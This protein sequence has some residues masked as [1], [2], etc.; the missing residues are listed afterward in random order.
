M[1]LVKVGVIGMGMMGSNHYR[2]ALRNPAVEL[3]A[4]CDNNIATLEVLDLPQNV[5]MT[6]NP[7]DLIGKVDAVIIATPTPFHGELARLFLSKGIACLV[8]K[9]LASSAQEGRELVDLAEKNGTTLMVGHVERFNSAVLSLPQFIE[10][11]FHF[12]F[13]RISPY[14]DRVRESIVADLMIHDLELMSYLYPH[15][16]VNVQAIAQSPKSDWHDFASVLVT[17]DDGATA[18]LVASRIGQQKVRSIEISQQDSVIL[19]DLLKQDIVISR[20]DRV[21]FSTEGGVSFKQHGIMEIPFIDRYGEPLMLEQQTFV[22]AISDPQSM[23]THPETALKALELV[24]EIESL[25]N[26]PASARV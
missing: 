14:S 5:L 6:T 15:D 11:P 22:S 21:E 1:S 26:V 7:E 2:V 24:E 16:V 9:P 17:F 4:I 13:R 3:V 8:E 12:E 10:N 20:V 18:N 23:P 25:L 19:A